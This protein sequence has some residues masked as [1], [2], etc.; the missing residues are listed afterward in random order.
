MYKKIYQ[1]IQSLE[2]ERERERNGTVHFV[3]FE[4]REREREKLNFLERSN[5]WNRPIGY[6]KILNGMKWTGKVSFADKHTLKLTKFK[7]SCEFGWT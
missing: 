6:S 1:N 2:R 7:I 3:F 4:E 5:P